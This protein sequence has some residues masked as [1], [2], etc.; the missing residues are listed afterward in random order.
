MP[1][2]LDRATQI[3]RLGQLARLTQAVQPLSMAHERLL[4]VHHAL[5][6]ALPAGGLARG[7]TVCCTGGAAMSLALALVGEAT[8]AGSWAGVVGLPSVG[9]AAAGE[10]GLALRRT[11][12]VATPPPS[13][14]SAVLATL[15]D[16]TDVV[17]AG[18]PGSFRPGDARRLQ[19]RVQA[20]G[21]ALVLVGD[22]GPVSVDVVLDVTASSWEGLGSGHGH[23]QRRRV[24][25]Q[26][27]GRR[28][29][30][31]RDVELW[32]PGATGAP[33]PI[34]PAVTNTT[35]TTTTNTTTN[36]TTTAWSCAG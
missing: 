22:P 18:V 29:G 11:V 13:Q 20:G 12:F 25:L 21:K 28:M 23:L 15:V 33:E 31:P 32:L 36:T 7:S 27:R 19:A 3:D 8:Q 26:A 16:G 5:T 10:L 6:A 2:A 34:P 4:P 9:L 17:V 14:W 24:R 35:T 1:S 30:R